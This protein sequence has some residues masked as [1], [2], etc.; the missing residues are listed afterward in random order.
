VIRT[1][2]N[3]WTGGG[4]PL[5]TKPVADLYVTIPNFPRGAKP[6]ADVALKFAVD[7]TGRVSD[8]ERAE[9]DRPAAIVKLACE[10]LVASFRPPPAVDGTGVPVPSVQ[11][12]KVL[13][14]KD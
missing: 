8:C 10:Q 12:A 9:A 3:W 6:P 2:I 11:G 13:L 7:A 14:Q 4:T 1:T 5:R